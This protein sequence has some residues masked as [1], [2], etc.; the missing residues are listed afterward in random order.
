MIIKTSGDLHWE[1][2]SLFDIPMKQVTAKLSRTYALQMYWTANIV[3]FY[4]KGISGRILFTISPHP[5]Y[6]HQ[7]HGAEGQRRTLHRHLTIILSFYDH[8]CALR[9]HSCHVSG[10]HYTRPR[11]ESIKPQSVTHA[12]WRDTDQ[13]WSSGK[14]LKLWQQTFGS[15]WRAFEIPSTQKA[16]HR[17]RRV[18]Q[19]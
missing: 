19:F 14:T 11:L 10:E 13:K 16:L 7:Q 1:G 12:S 15:V 8:V 17:A 3:L 18:K 6:L 4:Q 2:R 9:D 5:C